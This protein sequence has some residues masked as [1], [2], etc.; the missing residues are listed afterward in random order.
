M[1]TKKF[2][3]NLDL[4]KNELQNAV[5]QNLATDPLTPNQ[6]QFWY[7]TTDDR[8]KYY[9]GAAVITVANINDIAGLLDFKGGYDANTNTPNL[10][11]SPTAGT[12]KKGDYY[13]VTA[14]GTF[15]T[16]PL[17]IGDS[18]FANIDD[19]ASF[20]DWT[21]VQFNLTD[22]TETRKGVAEI[23]TQAETDAGTDDTRFVTPAKLKN[24]SFLQGLTNLVNK[25]STTTTIGTIAGAQTITH[26]LGTRD[27]VVNVYDATTFDQYSVEIVNTTINS[28]T[29]AANGANVSVKVVVIG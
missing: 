28:V 29:I 9:D 7:N 14:A 2:L 23:A 19:P 10:D 17:E 22:A 5:I 1:A 18:L 4:N 3:H 25:Y 11:S 12:I 26:S 27:V 8:I 20:S 6:G 16:E 13:V 15:F 21:L 24:A